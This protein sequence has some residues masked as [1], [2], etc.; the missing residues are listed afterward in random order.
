MMKRYL[1][2]AHNAYECPGMRDSIYGSTDSLDSFV[3]LMKYDRKHPLLRHYDYYEA[4]DLQTGDLYEYEMDEDG[5][6]HAWFIKGNIVEYGDVSEEDNGH[7]DESLKD[8]VKARL[9]E[10]VP[11]NGELLIPKEM[12][13][14]LYKAALEGK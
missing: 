3:P 5:A 8:V 12:R 2:F 7:E 10:A 9:D 1:V 6:E 14:M 13:N 4:L 11:H